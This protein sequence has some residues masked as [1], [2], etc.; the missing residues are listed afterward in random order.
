MWSSLKVNTGLLEHI[1]GGSSHCGAVEMSLTSIQE[2]ACSILG[3]T[4]WVRDPEFL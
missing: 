3:I 2:D 4:Q 1:I